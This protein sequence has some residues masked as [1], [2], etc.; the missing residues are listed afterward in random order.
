MMRR[1]L[2]GIAVALVWGLGSH[3][4]TVSAAS[5]TSLFNQLGGMDAVTKLGNNLLSSLMKDPRLSSLLGKVDPAA[6]SPKVANQLCST[7]GGGCP[8]AFTPE[9]MSAAASKLSPDQKKAVSENFS[10][11]LGSVSSNPLVQQAVTK[12]LGSNL[13]GIVGALL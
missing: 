1:T 5:A 8:A 6:A 10:S 2:L 3:A 4:S 9:Q 12:A 7:L 11:V 13:S